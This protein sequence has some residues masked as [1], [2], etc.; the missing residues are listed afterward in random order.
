MYSLSASG[1]KELFQA[2]AAFIGQHATGPLDAMIQSGGLKTTRAS[3]HRAAFRI[4]GPE[5][6][7]L[8]ARMHHGADTHQA[9]LQRHIQRGTREAVI[10][11]RGTGRAQRHHLGMRRRVMP[12]DRLVPAFSN[13]N[14]V[15]YQHRTHRHFAR[16]LGLA[17]QQQGMLHPVL[18]V[19][20]LCVAGE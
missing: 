1:T 20:G 9:G 2:L 14:S 16:G 8:H 10:A 12:F 18:I 7:A 4:M 3:C 5:Y 13:T 11:Q 19:H 17:S 15:I 6:Q